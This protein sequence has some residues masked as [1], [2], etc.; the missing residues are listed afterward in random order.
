MKRRCLF[1]AAVLILG[2]SAR[3]VVAF[4]DRGHKAVALIAFRQLSEEQK[5]KVHDIL[6]KHPHYVEFLKADKPANAPL[7]EWVAMQAS[8]WP[9]WVRSNHE[10]EF[11]KPF[12]HYV[13]IPIKRL[14]GA[15]AAVKAEIEMNIA[16][17]PSKPSSGQLLKE[18]PKRLAE[19][20]DGTTEEKERAV[21]L[22]WVFHQVGDI[23]QPLHAAALFTRK[24]REGDRGGNNAFVPWNG[25]AENLHSIWDG[26]VGWDEFAGIMM[27]RYDVV[28]LMARDFQHRHPVTAAE[29]E[30][31]TF[32]D[33]AKESRELADKEAYSFDGTPLRITFNFDHHHHLS[34]THMTPL[35]D[36]YAARAQK[37]AEKRVTLA[38]LRLADILKSIP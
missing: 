37:V 35:P 32:E 15:S 33:W 25:R 2:L 23:H 30:V 5:A 8:V 26:V 20:R 12:H 14:D 16:E 34:V 11:S 17:L 13:N 22:C 31:A 7:D 38:G 36:G 6:K 9:D 3:S 24:S 1:L 4:H 10:D 18:A 28:D 21:A 27:N 29:R 19:V